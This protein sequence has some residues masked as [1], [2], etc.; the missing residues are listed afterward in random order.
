MVM[1]G[2]HYS[3]R[4]GLAVVVAYWNGGVPRVA[5]TS[6]GLAPL[7]DGLAPLTQRDS[8]SSLR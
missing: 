2:R 1:L 6:Y 5:R 4:P 3:C 7:L 8:M